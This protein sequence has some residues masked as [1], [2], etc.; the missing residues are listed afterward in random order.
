MNAELLQ[1]YYLE[2]WL[3]EPLKGQVT[4]RGGSTHLAPKAA[5]VLNC[6]ANAPGEIVSRDALL[7]AVWGVGNGSQEALSH[8]VSEVRHALDDHADSPHFIQTLP[9]RGYRLLITP[10]MVAD[11]SSSVVLGAAD[12]ARP[13]DIGFI[14][15]LKRRGVL[16]T[17][18]GYMVVGW[19]LIQIADIVFDQLHFPDIVGTFVTVLVI[20]GLPIALILSWFLEIHD[21]R[22]VLHEL[23]PADA[24]RRR[25]SRTYVSI[26]SALGMAG[27]LVFLF[28]Q[29]IG[30]PEREPEVVVTTVVPAELPPIVENSIAV[31]PFNNFDG[32]D[33]TQI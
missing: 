16:E 32:S 23:S 33:E 11:A 29:F 6:L 3:I 20:A 9:K 12:G 22:A 1:G 13:S 30:L 18:V 25:F 24:R 8:A 27:V 4:G 19:L 21:G 10:E 31:L 5:E 17:L 7:D 2:D 14:E 26:L 28:D 15:N